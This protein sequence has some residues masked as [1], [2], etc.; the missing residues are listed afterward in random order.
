LLR[1]R[2]AIG[3]DAAVLLRVL[4]GLGGRGVGIDESSSSSSGIG[5]FGCPVGGSICCDADS[6]DEALVGRCGFAG[7]GGNREGIGAVGMKPSGII[8]ARGIVGMCGGEGGVAACWTAD[9]VTRIVGASS[10]SSL[11]L[12]NISARL[13][14]AVM[15]G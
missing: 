1:S 7:V 10:S 9:L 6:P 11:L 3:W 13:G 4:G 12:L 8:S 14:A 15:G 2:L 5:G